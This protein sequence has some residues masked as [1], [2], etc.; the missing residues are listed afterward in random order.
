M[1]SYNRP[2]YTLVVKA[3]WNTCQKKEQRERDYCTRSSIKSPCAEGKQQ[4][5][6]HAKHRVST[7]TLDDRGSEA[8]ISMITNDPHLHAGLRRITFSPGSIRRRVMSQKG[9]LGQTRESGQ[10]SARS[11]VKRREVEEKRKKL[12]EKLK[13][14]HLYTLHH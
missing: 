3:E 8:V 2:Q 1:P 7:G 5:Q 6:R 14:R 13:S 10:R 12:N 11:E 4:S 9:R